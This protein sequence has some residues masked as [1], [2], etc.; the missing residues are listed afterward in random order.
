MANVFLRRLRCPAGRVDRGVDLHQRQAGVVE[1]GFARGG[2]LDAVN[3]A[4]QQLDPDLIFQVADLPAER[5]L[6]GVQPALGRLGEAA[7]FGDGNEIAK[8][9]ELHR[10]PMLCGVC[11]PLTKS[12]SS[13]SQVLSLWAMSDLVKHWNRHR[14]SATHTS[15]VISH[16][17]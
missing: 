9:S 6:R 12:F 1:K 17:S 10:A 7:H 4:R 16:R 3:A 11:H 15:R 8:M 14:W 5:R 2:Q 13:L